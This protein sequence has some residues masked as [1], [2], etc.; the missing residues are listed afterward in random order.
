MWIE[1]LL[2][3]LCVYFSIVDIRYQIIPNRVTHPLLLI[4]IVW[5][6]FESSFFMGLIPALVLAIIFLIRPAFIGAGDIKLF[7]IIGLILGFNQ[8]ILVCTIVFFSLFIKSIWL[9]VV[10]KINH[11]IVPMAPYITCGVFLNVLV[12]TLFN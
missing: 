11:Q 4:L 7:A 2:V 9:K 5:R 3:A 12:H 8:I 10:K 1:W 6:L